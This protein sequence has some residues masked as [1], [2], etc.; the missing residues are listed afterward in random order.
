MIFMDIQM[1]VMNGYEATKSIRKLAN[2]KK[3]DIPIVAMTANAFGT[4]ISACYDAGMNGYV[5]KPVDI[6]LVLNEIRKNI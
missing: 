4:D 2:K 1:P 3:A 6:K 5:S